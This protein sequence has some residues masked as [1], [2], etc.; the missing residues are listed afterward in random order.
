MVDGGVAGWRRVPLTQGA[1]RSVEQFQHLQALNARVL[2]DDDVVM[3]GASE[4]FCD[5]L[6][7]RAF[8]LIHKIHEP[9]RIH[10][11]HLA[12]LKVLSSSESGSILGRWLSVRPI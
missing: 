7:A 10:A 2:A 12:R 11:A 5:I 6:C 1:R 9:G 3:R 8:D 4:G